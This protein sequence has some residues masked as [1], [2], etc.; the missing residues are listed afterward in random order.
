MRVGRTLPALLLLCVVALGGCSD[1]PSSSSSSSTASD[2]PTSSAPS[3]A[4]EEPSPSGASESPS[5]SPSDLPSSRIQAVRFHRAVLGSSAADTEQEV[6]VVDAW[7][8]YWQAATDTYY[9]RRPVASLDR[10]A[11]DKARRDVLGY[12]GRL[13]ADDQRVVGWARDNITDVTVDGSRATV[14]DCTENFT[15]SVDEEGSAITYPT[16]F[17]DVTGVLE[18][19]QGRW[20]VTRA[21][22]KDR[23]ATC[24]E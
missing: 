1:E 13:R 24:L 7:M 9:Y 14:R 23:K 5:S 10:V 15:F 22:S 18:M 2:S 17:Y 16:P 19:R 21:T 6:A 4:S 12:L 11:E 8:K 3:T 20:V